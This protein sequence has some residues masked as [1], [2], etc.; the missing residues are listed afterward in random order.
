MKYTNNMGISL[1]LAVWL[2]KD[3]YDYK[4]DPWH[5]SATTLR[6]STKQ[7]VLA[8]RVP[9]SEAITDISTI[10]A[11]R[12]GTAVHESI[13]VAWHDDSYKEQ[14]KVLGYPQKFIDN[15]I[16]NPISDCT[17]EP[18]IPIYIEQ[19]YAKQVGK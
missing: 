15:V 7:I 3:N 8:A 1:S 18:N 17:A 14:L 10:V 13:E 9:P 16:I 2:S 5:I 12:I 19:R 4:T 6:Q 11:S